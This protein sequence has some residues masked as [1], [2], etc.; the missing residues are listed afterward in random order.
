[1]RLAG[2]IALAAAVPLVLSACAKS[3]VAGA[4]TSSS[5]A[6]T[7]ASGPVI[8]G[9]PSLKGKTILWDWQSVP[10]NTFGVPM[11][12]G[13][14]AAA[15]AAGVT[16]QVEYGNNSDTTESQQIETS[17]AR[18]VAGMA[19]GIADTGLNKALCDAHKAGIPV[20]SF[21]I[22]GASGSGASCVQSFIGQSFVAA[23]Q[24]IAT[25]M[26][27]HGYIKRGDQV[28]CPVESPDQVYA[29]QRR[30]GVDDVLGKLGI[31][32]S[33]V[34]TGDDLAPAKT[35]LVQY[36]LGHRSTKAIICLGGTPLAEAPAAIKQAGMKIPVGGFDLSFPQIVT[37]LQNGSIVASVNQE[38]YAQGFYSVMELILEL[39]YGIPPSSINTSDNALITKANVGPFAKLVPSYQ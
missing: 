29:V 23:G 15:A 25:Y 17:V 1:M 7:S 22:D 38:P 10:S 20:V 13:A 31:T 35:T 18:H 36:L 32:C 30:Q 24:L 28:F 12:A 4:G 14:K 19:I 33:E 5:A 8:T 6:T 37:G 16:L 27:Q 21:N 3:A 9:G 39:K 2:A 26:V 34:G 11:L